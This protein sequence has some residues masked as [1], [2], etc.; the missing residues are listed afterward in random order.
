MPYVFF[1]CTLGSFSLVIPYIFFLCQEKNNRIISGILLNFKKSR[2]ISIDETLKLCH[3]SFRYRNAEKNGGIGNDRKTY[4]SGGGEGSGEYAGALKHSA[5]V[6]HVRGFSAG[7][8][9]LDRKSVV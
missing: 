9:Y 8:V 7:A 1:I 6:C 5:H 2:A 4:Y 3:N